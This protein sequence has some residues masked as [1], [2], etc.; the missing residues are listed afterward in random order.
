VRRDAR[1]P[2]D[3]PPTLLAVMGKVL[4][5]LVLLVGVPDDVE[6]GG[7]HPAQLLH[8]LLDGDCHAVEVPIAVGP[9]S[10]VHGGD[11]DQPGLPMDG[12]SDVELRRT[13]Q[14]EPSV[15]RVGAVPLPAELHG[16][17]HPRTAGQDGVVRRGD[18]GDPCGAVG[19]Y[20][21]SWGLPV[22]ILNAGVRWAS[23]H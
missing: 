12:Q 1:R 9:L 5:V 13:V 2:S 18:R 15:D 20:H 3:D 11:G 14:L 22:V 17:R 23:W 16:V 21:L 8:G 4:W 6:T 10:G 19:Y 7:P